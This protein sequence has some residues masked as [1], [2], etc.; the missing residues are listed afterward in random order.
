MKKLLFVSVL[1]MLASLFCFAVAAEEHHVFDA[2]D[3]FE[4]TSVGGG[5]RTNND[6]VI[7]DNTVYLSVV[8]TGETTFGQDGTLINFKIANDE[9]NEFLLKEF[10]ILKVAYRSNIAADS[11]IDFNL[12]M[13]YLGNATRI[14]GYVQ[15]FDHSGNHAEFITELP[16]AFNGGENLGG[17]YSWDNVDDDSFVNYLRLKPYYN[18]KPIVKNEYFNI[19][20]IGFFKTVEDAKNYKHV[21]KLSLELTSLELTVKAA[22]KYVG[23][24]LQLEALPYPS[25]ANM[26]DVTYASENPEIATVDKTGLVTAVSAGD[27]YITVQTA[28]GLSVK[29]HIYVLDEKL[30]AVTFVPQNIEGKKIV[31]NCLGDSITTYA[32]SPEGGINYH[33]WLAKW[34]QINNKDY[35]ISG[36]SLTSAGQDPFVER[37]D[38]M[39]DN[40]DIIIV[41]GGTNDSGRDLGSLTDRNTQY[42]YGALR[43]LMEGLIEKYP[44]KQI[45]FL[46]PIKRCESGQTPETK[47]GFGYTLGDFAKAVEEMGAI[48][49]IP[50][51]DLYTPEELD[52]T[53]TVISKSGTGADG[54]WHDAVCESDLMPDGLH[55]SGKGHEIMAKYILDKLVELEIVEIYEGTAPYI[56]GSGFKDTISHWGCDAIDFCV[57]KVLFNGVTATE[58]MPNNTMTRGMLVTVLSRLAKD[59]ENKTEYPFT[60]FDGDA[61]FANG[62]SFAF[63]N[64]LVD[65]GES[66]R[67]DDDITREE[68]ADMLYRYAKKTG[69]NTELAE[70]CFADADKITP[71]M[72]DA[73]AYCIKAQIF[74]GYDDNTVNPTGKATRAEVATMIMRFVNAK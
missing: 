64:G 4:M 8:A 58:F 20:Y 15:Q 73:V 41:K 54:K 39:V 67:P 47:N 52:F 72:K 33:D 25:Y 32:P 22:R 61:W 36:A 37:Y 34:Y 38:D 12:G 53:S 40:A 19:E 10:P 23:E 24:T 55:P 31:M 45:V 48:Y 63:A 68:L 27:T 18:G 71:S 43:F 46:T 7:E 57:R 11:T 35:G 49:G 13:N 70:I 14:W 74:K 59:T 9:K 29:S 60:D 3:L 16:G 69:K 21:S 2:T 62:V 42:F 30:P 17:A 51:I 56:T 65:A 44:D 1:L 50:V 28:S 66:F 26:V 5:L 6:I